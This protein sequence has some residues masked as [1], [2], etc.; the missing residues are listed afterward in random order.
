MD[1]TARLKLIA[2]MQGGVDKAKAEM[3]A[4]KAHA[5]AHGK[6]MSEGLFGEL[7]KGAKD[8]FTEI[9]G[10]MK[11]ALGIGSVVAIAETFKASMEAYDA[12]GDTATKLGES[13]EA[14]QRVDYAAKLS[15]SSMEG[16]ASAVLKLE[17]NLGDLENTKAREALERYGLTVE[18]VMSLPLDQKL[19]AYA[20]AFG[21][22]RADGTGYTDL[23]TMMGKSAGELIPLLEEGSDG[24]KAMF[25]DAMVIDDAGVKRLGEMNDAFDG[26]I[27][28]MKALTAESVILGDQTMKMIGNLAGGQKDWFTGIMS[29]LGQGKGMSFKDQLDLLLGR[30][31]QQ[32]ED[33]DAAVAEAEK[34]KQELQKTREE[35]AKRMQENSDKA[36]AAK[37]DTEMG[38][39]QGLLDKIRKSEIAALP[40]GER[41]GAF[42][43]QIEDIYATMDSLGGKAY[44][45][46]EQGLTSWAAALELVA[47]QTKKAEDIQ[48]WE[49]VLGIIS[50]VRDAEKER[51]T[52]NA[53]LRTDAAENARK[54]E[55]HRA[56]FTDR[57]RSQAMDL[58]PDERKRAA[59]V[60]DLKRQLAG[61]TLGDLR[62]EIESKTNAG[63]LESASRLEKRYTRAID[64]AK[65]AAAL[66]DGQMG[67]RVGGAQ[68]LINILT[69]KGAN[70]LGERQVDLL[71][72]VLGVL[73]EIKDGSGKG[74]GLGSGIE[75]LIF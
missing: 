22:A 14:L 32:K 49:K 52:L 18:G 4:L 31:D 5:K 70:Q 55:E 45:K 61:G 60:E 26:M 41:L 75:D 44:A 74:S 43:K 40:E 23:L 37:T 24:I 7:G 38:K 34:K 58:L 54:T 65:G 16:V 42:E 47:Q 51:A 50:K 10:A 72:D 48:A 28:K 62:K 3:A 71:K 9:G 8:N 36:A 46:N 6:G 12:L 39:A 15:G 73:K 11:A 69:G 33:N 53:K 19:L 68:N 67:Q 27:M 25:G 20:D 64:D 2:E 29:A 17:K 1:V 35:K 21:K 57:A 30:V 59:L 66:G 56:D 13:S 63:D